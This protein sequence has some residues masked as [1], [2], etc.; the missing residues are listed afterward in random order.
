MP[1]SPKGR[2]KPQKRV[3]RIVFRLIVLGLLAVVVILMLQKPQMEP[4]AIS[5]EAAKRFR[6]NLTAM[7]KAIL[8]GKP[9]KLEATEEGINS[10]IAEDI[11][12]SEQSGK[13]VIDKVRI[14]LKK[15]QLKCIILMKLRGKSIYI[16]L[17]GKPLLIDGRLSLSPDRA[18]VGK[19][20]MLPRMLPGI[21]KQLEKGEGIPLPKF[22]PGARDLQVEEGKLTV[23]AKPVAKPAPPG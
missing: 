17:S 12:Q 10:Q 6:A 4:L 14:R 9:F 7:E 5:A 2:A 21:L 1:Q 16:S 23:Q 20:P 22:P 15:N 11:K 8:R 18:A 3:G 13:I 19:M